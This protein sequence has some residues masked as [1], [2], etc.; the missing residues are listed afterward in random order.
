MKGQV[1]ADLIVECT[2]P[3]PEER[4]PQDGEGTQPWTLHID[5]ASN[6]QGDGAGI[7][8]ESPE[9]LISEHALRFGFKASNNAA[10]YEAILAGLDLAKAAGAKHVRVNSDSALV[11]GQSNSEFEA[12][13][14]SMKWYQE[15][16]R[17]SM[18]NFDNNI[19]LHIPRESNTR[20]DE[21]AK[22]ASAP[23]SEFDPA[24]YVE[25]LASPSIDRE[26]IM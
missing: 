5:G 11:V 24:V 16:V 22:L 15:M 4:L 7:I 21:L 6:G 9:G 19:F 18:A 14:E 26:I 3:Q 8:L 1:M 25:H 12:R 13:E 20:A 2:I 23:T 17:R 10:E